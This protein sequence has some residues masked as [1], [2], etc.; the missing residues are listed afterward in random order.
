MAY[1]EALANKIRK[2]IAGHKGFVEKKMFG[3]L[4]FMLRGK[5]CCGILKN[6]LV[7]RVGSYNYK[8]ILIKPHVRP[9]EFYPGH[10]KKGFVFVDPPGYKTNAPLLKW[11]NYAIEFVSSLPKTKHKK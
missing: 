8:R 5:M 3:G 1:D 2:A 11:L 10:P 7:V 6:N 4:T 9:M